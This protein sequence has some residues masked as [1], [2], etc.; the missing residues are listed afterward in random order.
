M[1][2]DFQHLQQMAA[3]DWEAL[4]PVLFFIIYAV[5]QVLGGRK[6]GKKEEGEGE[7]SVQDDAMERARQIREEIRRK[8]AERQANQQPLEVPAN[9]AQRPAYDLG[10][11]PEPASARPAPALMREAPAEPAA[12]PV[13]QPRKPAARKDS[14]AGGGILKRL[15]EQ[16]ARLEQVKREQEAARK[17]ARAMADQVRGYAPAKKRTP[18]RPAAVVPVAAP[19]GISLRQSI[20]TDLANPASIRKAILLREILD[21]PVGMR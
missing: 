10:R 1:N 6:S 13:P 14:D 3:F 19:A 7:E 20:R 15:H 2:N 8:I 16:R 9:P 4:L 5:S 17:S 12:V 18:A 21:K 11:P